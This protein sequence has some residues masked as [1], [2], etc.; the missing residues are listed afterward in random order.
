MASTTTTTTT[1]A[2]TTARSVK[3]IPMSTT[4]STGHRENNPNLFQSTLETPML[5]VK[6]PSL[7]STTPTLTTAHYLPATNKPFGDESLA[8]DD[9]YE[10]EDDYFTTNSKDLQNYQNQSKFSGVLHASASYL[11]EFSSIAD[12]EKPQNQENLGQKVFSPQQF[13][14]NQSDGKGQTQS[15]IKPAISFQQQQFQ[16]GGTLT[17]TNSHVTVDVRKCLILCTYVR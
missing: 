16:N 4:P 2:T 7:P 11:M 5:V 15:V 13:I 17:V 3:P 12:V 14:L 10:Y 1:A 9:E 8:D 6:K